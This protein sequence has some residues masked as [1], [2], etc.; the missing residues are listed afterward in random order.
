M[1][2][3]FTL[4]I[5]AMAMPFEKK[6]R[7]MDPRITAIA[8]HAAPERFYVSAVTGLVTLQMLKSADIGKPS[9]LHPVSKEADTRMLMQLTHVPKGIT[10]S[11]HTGVTT[12][13]FLPSMPHKRGTHIIDPGA[14]W[15]QYTER[16]NGSVTCMNAVLSEH[17]IGPAYMAYLT[18]KSVTGTTDGSG[19]NSILNQAQL[20]AGTD[21][22]TDELNS[23]MEE[24]NF[25]G[26]KRRK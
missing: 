26:P 2:L 13:S 23:I 24:K 11:M 22:L 7:P 4:P 9:L 20:R 8:T 12:Y 6:A 18:L 25:P 10:A 17:G 1:T 16:R 5:Q 19:W 14:A 21:V 15:F 3:A